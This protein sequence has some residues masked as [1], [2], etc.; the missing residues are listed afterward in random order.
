MELYRALGQAVGTFENKPAFQTEEVTRSYRQLWERIN[1]VG[2]YLKC[3]IQGER[4]HIAV[5]IPNTLNFSYALFGILGAGHIALPFNPLLTAEELAPLLDHG[6]AYCLLYD[7]Q[8]EDKAKQAVQMA[9]NKIDALSVPCILNENLANSQPLSPQI[10]ENELSMIMYTSGTT[11]DPKGVMLTHKNFYSNYSAYNDVFQ[12]SPED[13]FP[14]VLPLFHSFAMTAIL[15]GGLLSGSK[16]VLFPSFVPQKI[17]DLLTREQNIILLGVSPMLYLV[18]YM[19]DEKTAKNHNLRYTVS[20]GGPLPVDV[21]HYF[22]KKI[23]HPILEGYGLTEAAP[24]V[25]SNPPGGNRVG[26]IGPAIPGVEV[27]IRNEK[28]EKVSNGEVGEL[29]VKGDN[30]MLGY[31][32]NPEATKN[33]FFEGGWLRTGDLGS[34]DDIGYIQIK[35]R[36]KDLIISGGENIYP[37]E[38]EEILMRHPAVKEVAVVAQSN[39]LRNEVPFAF[40]VLHE[41]YQN[42]TTESELR[43]FC[44]EHMAEYKVPEGFDFIEAMP[45]TAKGS[46][47]KEVLKKRLV[48]VKCDW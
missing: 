20:G 26:T 5:L 4:R 21:F 43:K 46:I 24:V 42:Q 48:G 28:G 37:R 34:I 40:V 31:Y 15:L 9:S 23:N 22:N 11:G 27:E 32:R 14:C 29:C 25:A 1:I 44:R 30:V 3:N 38:V 8:L 10:D 2:N 41:E 12:F 6:E 16:I 33:V 13:T 17:V 36:L 47:Q 7:P 18:A 35:G 45:K 19:A 39:K